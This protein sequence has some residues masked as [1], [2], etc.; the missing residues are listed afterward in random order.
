MCHICHPDF[1]T[2]QF[3]YIPSESSS[4]GRVERLGVV[5]ARLLASAEVTDLEPIQVHDGLLYFQSEMFG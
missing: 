2:W 1:G 4:P 5:Y 3:G